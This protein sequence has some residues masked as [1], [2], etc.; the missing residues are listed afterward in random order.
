MGIALNRP[1][2]PIGAAN[3][4][5]R[6]QARRHSVQDFAGPLSIKSVTQGSV[7]WKTGGRELVVDRGG[8]LVLN[9]GE[10]YSME[11]D[12][13]DPVST[14]CVFFTPGFVESVCASIASDDLEPA[15][16]PQY[17]LQRLHTA[18]SGVLPRMQAIAA[19]ADALDLEQHYLELAHSLALLQSD[20]RRRVRMMPAR[21]ASTREEL[22]RRV[23][24]GQ[25][26]LHACATESLSLE[27]LAREACLSPFH[28]HRA[29]TCA[30]G[31]TPHE[32]RTEL[33]LAY[34]RRLL[35]TTQLP[36]IDICAAAG[37]ESPASFTHLF[38]RTFDVPPS[39]IRNLRQASA[40]ASGTY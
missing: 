6:G 39:K 27:T 34:A 4:V 26:L 17:F 28:F 40:A 36:V 14:L 11:I 38:R 29:F 25:E 35:E 21:R 5:L 32:Y 2:A 33:R 24:R 20:I 7:A 13:R 8:F 23:R 18:D 22:F 30:F 31:R 10:P 3:A 15:P 9:H 37:F 12:S 1:T 16:A 19:S